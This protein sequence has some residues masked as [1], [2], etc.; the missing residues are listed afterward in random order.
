MIDISIVFAAVGTMLLVGAF[1]NKLSSRFNVPILLIFLLFGMFVGQNHSPGDLEFSAISVAGTIAMCFI[2]FSGGLDTK[3]SSIKPVLL[4]GGVLATIGVILTCLFFAVCARGIFY[5]ELSF[6]GCLLLG[7]MI[8]STDAAAVFGILS[9]KSVGLKGRLRPV[10]E[11]E[12]GSNDPMAYFLT[13]FMIEIVLG[14]NAFGITA[15]LLLLYRMAGGVVLGIL[16]GMFGKLLY[17]TKLDYEGL[18]FVFDIAIVLLAYGLTEGISANGMMACYVCGI[19]MNHRGFNYQKGITRF[20]DGVS[21]LMQVLLFTTLGIFVDVSS[22]PS[23]S[24]KGL[25]LAAILLF[26]A[27]P[28]AVFISLTGQSFSWREKLLISW[29]GLRGAAPIVLA[30]FPL[31]Y[32]VG[33]AKL[34]FNLIFFMVLVS[35]LI[36]GMTLMPLAKLLKLDKT[37]SGRER[38]PLE[39]ESTPATS[40]QEMKEF[41]VPEDAFYAGKTIAELSLPRGVLITLIRRGKSLLPPNGQT[42]IHEGDGLLIMGSHENL[43]RVQ[44]TFFPLSD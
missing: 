10:L 16:V 33:S 38:M 9:G 41:I 35:M 22:L 7:A 18:Y 43:A 40:G 20:S 27:R 44:S 28:A 24:F 23:I 34:Y 31:A 39:L 15:V 42:V 30:T 32:G 17:K 13:L 4:P 29:V 19:T 25:L 37:F 2:L 1:S 12:S 8:S 36:Q 11:L 14:K 6:A 3:F 5:K 21:W 26:V